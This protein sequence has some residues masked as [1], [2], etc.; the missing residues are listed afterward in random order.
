M[1]LL[2]H[3]QGSMGRKSQERMRLVPAG[4]EAIGGQ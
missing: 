3:A 1:D 4:G 2:I